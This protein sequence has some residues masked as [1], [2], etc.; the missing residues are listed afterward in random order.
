MLV[1]V[2]PLVAGER[3]LVWLGVSAPGYTVYVQRPATTSTT[4]WDKK[5]E[6]ALF[7]EK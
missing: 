1:T 7:L 3:D 2:L 4:V 6:T 5:N